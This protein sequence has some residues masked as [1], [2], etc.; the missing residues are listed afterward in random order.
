MIEQLPWTTEVKNVTASMN[1]MSKKIEGSL[2]NLN[3]KLAVIGKKLHR[4]DLTGLSKKSSF[5][6]D[7][8]HLFTEHVDAFIFLIKIDG[9]SNLVKELDK[10]SI[11]QFLIDFANILLSV[12]D[13][14]EKEE[15]SAY[16][17]FGSEFALL[18]KQLDSIKAK[19][20]AKLL[21]KLFTKLGEKYNKAD[22]AHIGIAPFNPICTTEE[23]L[24]A[25]NEAYEQAQLIGANRYYIRTSEDRAKAIAEWK[26]LVFSIIDNQDYQV[27]FIGQ[28]ENFQTGQ[29]IMEEAFTQAFDNNGNLISIGPFVSIA[30][31][32]AKIVD[33]DKGVTLKAVEYIKTRQIQ[34]AVA[35]NLST[36]TIKDSLFRSWLVQLIKQ[37]KSIAQQ[38][39]FSLSVYAVA[40]DIT[41]YKE[42]ITFV[43]KL[44][45]KVIIK[46][47][48][49]QSISTDIVSS[50]P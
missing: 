22:I 29:L 16:R 9:L 34:H 4:D 5:E 33:L 42:F 32:F 38:L 18:I 14:Y 49:T 36:R 30:E 10:D 35:I 48:E 12:S 3:T 27:T 2:K 46:R 43:H 1:M 45:A 13:R 20:I 11:D 7:M 40:K 8:K 21:G 6:S 15:I 19:Q 23:I 37:N 39:V 25:A 24:L 50:H 26:S 31:K 28:V 41:V 17:F 44:N 47:F